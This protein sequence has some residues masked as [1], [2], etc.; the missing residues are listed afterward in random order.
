MSHYDVLTPLVSLLQVDLAAISAAA[1][2]PTEGAPPLDAAGA[3]AFAEA[4]TTMEHDLSVISTGLAAALSPTSADPM[5]D[6]QRQLEAWRGQIENLA[7]RT[8]LAGAEITQERER[9]IGAARNAVLAAHSRLES[10]DA[11][12]RA[13]VLDLRE[14][15]KKVGV[16]LTHVVTDA[17]AAFRRSR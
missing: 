13:S 11:D 16:D 12:T 2:A 7:V 9:L 14:G 1:Q 17:V 3:V 5:K 10:V 15:M 8:S 4:V 6:L